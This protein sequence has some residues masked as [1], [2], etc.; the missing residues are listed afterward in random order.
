MLCIEFANCSISDCKS[1]TNIGKYRRHRSF[2]AVELII[3]ALK[4]I[5][6]GCTNPTLAL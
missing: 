1:E 6:G 2:V 3:T 5:E 4:C